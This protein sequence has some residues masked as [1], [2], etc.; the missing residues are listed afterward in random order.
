V[1]I[2]SDLFVVMNLNA[3]YREMQQ[4]Q[5]DFYDSDGASI[6]AIAL[7][8]TFSNEAVF[9]W[10]ENG[11][12]INQTSRSEWAYGGESMYWFLYNGTF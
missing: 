4:L 11:T 5:Y 9:S 3:S 8:Q 2:L 1:N 10:T 7:K 6:G 12:W